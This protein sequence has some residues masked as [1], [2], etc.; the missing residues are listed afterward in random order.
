MFG[1]WIGYLRQFNQT[2]VPGYLLRSRTLTVAVKKYTQNKSAPGREI[3]W[4][5]DPDTKQRQPIAIPMNGIGFKVL[6]NKLSFNDPVLMNCILC[7]MII[8][9]YFFHIYLCWRLLW[10]CFYSNSAPHIIAGSIMKE[11]N[12]ISKA[13]DMLNLKKKLYSNFADVLHRCIEL[14]Y[15]IFPFSLLSTYYSF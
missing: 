13:A 10:K 8:L 14:F 9:R 1:L 12:I 15:G 6:Y 7:I 5:F 2:T 4:S 11:N 3:L